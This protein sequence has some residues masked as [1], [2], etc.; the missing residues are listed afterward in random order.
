MWLNGLR[1]WF[2]YRG[3]Q[4]CAANNLLSPGR[5]IRRKVRP[6]MRPKVQQLQDRL[7]PSASPS[8]RA[9]QRRPVTNSD[10]LGKLQAT[11]IITFQL[12][13]PSNSLVNALRQ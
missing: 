13:F 1:R 11:S 6:R 3:R 9:Q 4:V 7:V 2:G 12:Y 10:T 8:R 5:P